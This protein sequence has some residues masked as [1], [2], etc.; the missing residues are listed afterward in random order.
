[1]TGPNC[2]IG[3]FTRKLTGISQNRGGCWSQVFRSDQGGSEMKRTAGLV[4]GALTGVILLTSAPAAFADSRHPSP[5]QHAAGAVRPVPAGAVRPVADVR[6]APRDSQEA[7]R[8]AVNDAFKAAVDAASAKFD[9][10]M[11]SAKTAAAKAAARANL[12][13]DVASAITARQAAL[14]AIPKGAP[15]P[16][17]PVG[18]PKPRQTP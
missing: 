15:I 12:R 16:A 11:A 6:V 7:A 17:Q 3:G 4:A 9:Q 14:D 18:S 5:H 1:M 2:L 8:R 13:A 10:I